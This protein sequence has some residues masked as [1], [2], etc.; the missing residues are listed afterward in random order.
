MM[1]ILVIETNDYKFD[2]LML[3]LKGIRE[4]DIIR[5]HSLHEA[6]NEFVKSFH[7]GKP[8]NL[9][10]MDLKMQTYANMQNTIGTDTGLKL[11]EF[12]KKKHSEIPILLYMKEIPEDLQEGTDGAI[13]NNIV[14][15]IPFPFD[16]D[17][18]YEKLVKLIHGI[19]LNSQLKPW[20]LPGNAVARFKKVSFEEW[21]KAMTKTFPNH[22]FK[23]CELR[24]MYERIK[25]PRRATTGSAGYD[26]MAP[27]S[28]ELCP[29]TEIV[30]PTGIRCVFYNINWHLDLLPR[31]GHG[32][33][34]GIRLANTVGV[35]DSDYYMADN[36][37]HIMV[38][39]QYDGNPYPPSHL[40]KWGNHLGINHD[41]MVFSAGKAFCQGLFSMYG[42]TVDDD[43]YEK[44]DRWGGLGSTDRPSNRPPIHVRPP[45]H[46]HPHPCPKPED[47]DD[48]DKKDPTDPDTPDV[49]ENPDPDNP[50]VPDIG[51]GEG[52]GDN[53]GSEENPPEIPYPNEG[54]EGTGNGSEE[55]PDE[56]VKND[57]EDLDSF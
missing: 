35:I 42:V 1:R 6:L 55:N 30:I 20:K 3:I 52:D 45:H 41:T 38:K 28:F 25:L 9:I 23:R 49:P 12:L 10:I 27:F 7:S 39:M 57:E 24:M 5:R 14:G 47:P 36:E 19:D 40:H 53:N 11:L 48:E 46:H 18:D 37:G 17:D 44:E 16:P 31:S 34:T 29:G 32:F 43:E 2:S 21:V 51:D 33:K 13:E 56:N 22:R 50:E 8:I 54:N 26:I 4:C 15:H